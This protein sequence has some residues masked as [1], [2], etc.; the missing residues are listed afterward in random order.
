MHGN[1]L[2]RTASQLKSIINNELSTDQLLI[3]KTSTKCRLPK[4]YQTIQ[5]KTFEL[6]DDLGGSD[7]PH[8]PDAVGVIAAA[9]HGHADEVALVQ[10]WAFKGK[11]KII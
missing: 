7:W 3:N 11:W 10:H 6:L 9:Q 5:V 1:N 8:T 4:F 2:K